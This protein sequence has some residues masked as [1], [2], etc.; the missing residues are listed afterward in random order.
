M[1]SAIQGMT[2]LRTCTSRP[3]A[4]GSPTLFLADY[5]A[6]TWSLLPTC[7]G[8][9]CVRYRHE[10]A[11]DRHLLHA[12][13]FRTHS[14]VPLMRRHTPLCCLLLHVLPIGMQKLSKMGSRFRRAEESQS[15]LSCTAA[16]ELRRCKE[17]RLPLEQAGRNR[18][19]DV[20]GALAAVAQCVRAGRLRVRADTGLQGGP[21]PAPDHIAHLRSHQAM[22]CML[23]VLSYYITYSSPC[24]Y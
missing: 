19:G 9:L 18:H 10:P 5:R 8:T 14:S 23:S 1:A 2:E 21:A 6:S 16:C 24:R 12:V 13:L 17:E 3:S 7:R 4:G 20:R 11:A 22:R 15:L